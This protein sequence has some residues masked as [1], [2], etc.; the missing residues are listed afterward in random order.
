MPFEGLEEEYIDCT[1]LGKH[2]SVELSQDFYSMKYI[3]RMKTYKWNDA[4]GNLICKATVR[5]NDSG[6]GTVSTVYLPN[7]RLVSPVPT[8]RPASRQTSDPY[9]AKDY[10]HPD[11]F[12]YDYRDDFIDYEEAEDYWERYN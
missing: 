1:K 9:G 11:D 6:D 3:R 10:A 2:S 8:R 5:Y 4:N 7:S 12:Y